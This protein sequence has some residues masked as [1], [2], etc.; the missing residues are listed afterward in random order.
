MLRP[1]SEQHE[2]VGQP[3]GFRKNY[4]E[5]TVENIYPVVCFE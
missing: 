5:Q 2:R 4:V 1:N 3:R